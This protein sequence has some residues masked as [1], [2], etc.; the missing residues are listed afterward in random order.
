MIARRND[1]DWASVLPSDNAEL[2]DDAVRDLRDRLFQGLAKSLP[3]L[4]PIQELSRRVA[5]G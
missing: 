3:T 4:E 1:E 2:R 5:S